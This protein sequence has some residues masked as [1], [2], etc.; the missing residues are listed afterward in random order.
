MFTQDLGL[1]QTLRKDLSTGQSRCEDN[2]KVDLKVIVEDTLTGFI[3]LRLETSAG[4]YEH[5]IE[6]TVSIK[7][8]EFVWLREGLWPIDRLPESR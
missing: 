2:I 3:W 6:L 5:D 7:G 8:E 4:S 1:G